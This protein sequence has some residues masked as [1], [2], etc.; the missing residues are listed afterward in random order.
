MRASNSTMWR[1][2]VMIVMM[3]VIK[4]MYLRIMQ[5]NLPPMKHKPQ[6]LSSFIMLHPSEGNLRYTSGDNQLHPSILKIHHL[7]GY[8]KEQ[9]VKIDHL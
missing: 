7:S 5:I 3:K 9:E 4:R 1:S 8:Q 2:L 6:H